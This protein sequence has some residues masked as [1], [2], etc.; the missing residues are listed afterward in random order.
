[1]SNENN[2]VFSLADKQKSDT[3]EATLSCMNCGRGYVTKIPRGVTVR[4][5]NPKCT[6]CGCGHTDVARE[7]ERK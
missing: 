7:W 5:A 2:K 3:Y 4:E 6:N 1:M